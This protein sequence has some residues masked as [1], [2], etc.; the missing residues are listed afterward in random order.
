MGR[1][2]II[3]TLFIFICFIC[4]T[5]IILAEDGLDFLLMLDG[6]N[7]IPTGIAETIAPEPGA[8]RLLNPTTWVFLGIFMLLYLKVLWKLVSFNWKSQANYRSEKKKLKKRA[9]SSY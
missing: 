6:D 7:F 2:L 9:T 3:M 5:F 4:F 1:M 8:N